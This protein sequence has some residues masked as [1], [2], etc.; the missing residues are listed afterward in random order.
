MGYLVLYSKR[1]TVLLR[2]SSA[3]REPETLYIFL[4]VLVPTSSLQSTP[5]LRVKI[6][7]T[8]LKFFKEWRSSI[9]DIFNLVSA[10]KWTP[11]DQ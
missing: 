2:L 3:N 4:G 10:D 9:S 7:G 1:Y 5:N 8:A 6:M 11:G